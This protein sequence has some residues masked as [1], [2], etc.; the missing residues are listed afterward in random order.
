MKN[1]ARLELRAVDWQSCATS[2]TCRIDLNSDHV[3]V[4]EQLIDH[5]LS[6]AFDTLNVTHVEVRVTASP[7]SGCALN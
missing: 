5:V 7:Q 6:F 1:D 3:L 2:S 4:D